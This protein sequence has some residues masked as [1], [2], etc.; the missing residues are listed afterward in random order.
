MNNLRNIKTLVP[1]PDKR[2]NTDTIEFIESN[3]I[4]VEKRSRNI[5]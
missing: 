4:K 3:S 2:E 1:H 5:S